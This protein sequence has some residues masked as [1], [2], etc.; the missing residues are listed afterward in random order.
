MWFVRASAPQHYRIDRRPAA[1]T[2]VG[3]LQLWCFHR[4]RMWF[5]HAGGGN[6]RDSYRPRLHPVVSLESFADSQHSTSGFWR[7]RR[8]VDW[9]ARCHGFGF[10]AVERDGGTPASFLFVD[11]SVLADLGVHR[12]S[13]N[14]RNLA[15]DIGGRSRVCSATVSG[16]EFP[17]TMVG[18]CGRIVFLS[19][20]V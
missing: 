20:G 4:R 14:D 6:W 12:L 15:R 11:C 9:A 17:R 5:W 8:T 2:V 16:F 18:R 10:E 13:R 19:G 3:C 7:A 1:A